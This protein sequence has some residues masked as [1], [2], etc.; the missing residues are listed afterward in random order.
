MTPNKY[1]RWPAS[2][3]SAPPIWTRRDAARD[4][5]GTPRSGGTDPC[6][7]R[8]VA[9]TVPSGTAERR[10]LVICL[11][12][13][14]DCVTE[15]CIAVGCTA[16]TTFR[17]GCSRPSSLPRRSR[18]PIIRRCCTS[19]Y[20]PPPP[21]SLCMRCRYPPLLCI[22][23]VRGGSAVDGRWLTALREDGSSMRISGHHSLMAPNLAPHRQPYRTSKKG[24][25]MAG[26]G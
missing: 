18:I 5:T 4:D 1:I 23:N 16:S 13:L 26:P 10:Y 3:P 24:A 22:V 8:D 14:W 19:R 12:C 9:V 25:I 7:Q 11:D 6:A 17:R 21:P 2:L 20:P 15:T